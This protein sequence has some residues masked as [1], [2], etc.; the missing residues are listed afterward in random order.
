MKT[1]VK[2]FAEQFLLI[3]FSWILPS[4]TRQRSIQNSVKQ[5]GWSFLRS[6]SVCRLI[7][8]IGKTSNPSLP[9]GRKRL[10]VLKQT[11]SFQLQVFLRMY[12]LLLAL[13]I[14]F[15]MTQVLSY[16]NKSIDLHSKLMDWFLYDRNLR[17]ER[18]KGL[19]TLVRP[20]FTMFL[21]HAS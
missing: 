5:L 19:S 14:K 21:H 3:T 7:C 13:G 9:H 4:E 10:Y 17:H 20:S 11:Q 1:S 2:S 18:V 8:V 15:F 6:V 16:R 12:D